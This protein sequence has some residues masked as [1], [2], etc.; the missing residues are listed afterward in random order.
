MAEDMERGSFILVQ[1]V[2]IVWS[3][4]IILY[5]KHKVKVLHYWEA[6]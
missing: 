1:P 5:I 2:V 6:D 4:L 3:Q